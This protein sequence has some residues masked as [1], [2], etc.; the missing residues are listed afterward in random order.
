MKLDVPERQRWLMIAAGAGALLLI[1]NWAVI[2]PLGDAWTAHADEI[3]RLRRSIADGRSLLARGPH[4]QQLWAANRAQAL[5]RDQAQAEHDLIFAFENWSRVSGVELGAVKP[6]W[7]Q[8]ATTASS[9]LECRLDATGSLGALSRFL[10]ELGQAP[11]ALR[12]ES[13]ELTSRDETGQRLTL[14]LTVTGLRLF[15]L[16]GKS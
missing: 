16:E 7:K 14:G 15:P 10:Y 8:G 12:V 3:V 9:L 11:M 13:V 4:L 1:L 2:T 5:P 6:Q